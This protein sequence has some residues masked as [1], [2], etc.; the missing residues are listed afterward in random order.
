MH[1]WIDREFGNIGQN[2]DRGGKAIMVLFLF[3]QRDTPNVAKID[4]SPTATPLPFSR[5]FDLHE[6]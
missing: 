5:A 3:V 1:Q 4:E 2:E 6:K